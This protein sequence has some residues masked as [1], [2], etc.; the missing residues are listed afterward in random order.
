MPSE[1]NL[2]PPQELSRWA[3]TSCDLK[4]GLNLNPGSGFCWLVC[5]MDSLATHPLA[6][7]YSL[8]FYDLWSLHS[9]KT[10]G[11]LR[12][13]DILLKIVHPW[14]MHY[15]NRSVVFSFP[16]CLPAC[17]GS[18]LE[19]RVPIRRGRRRVGYEA[20]VGF[21]FGRLVEQCGGRAPDR[22]ASRASRKGHSDENNIWPAGLEAPKWRL[23]FSPSLLYVLSDFTYCVLL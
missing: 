3:H 11:F 16:L 12:T 4:L 13:K 5:G 8:P 20:S 22:K 21:L 15:S 17:S 19:V 23:S 10:P 7:R 9:Q 6:L 18:V 1:E 2:W 14:S